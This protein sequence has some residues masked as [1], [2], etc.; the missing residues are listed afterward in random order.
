VNIQSRLKGAAAPVAL[1]IALLAQPAFAQDQGD[2]AT[3]TQAGAEVA[4]NDTADQAIIVTGSRIQRT[5]FSEPNPIVTIDASKIEHYGTA[6]L[7]ELLANNPALLGSV[8]NIDAAGSNLVDAQSTGGNYLDLRNLGSSRTLVLVDGRRHVAGYPGTAS[9]DVNT[10][11]TDLIDRIDVLTG[12]VSAVY[13]ADGVSGVVN[14][15]MK[16][17]FEGLNLRGQRTI[18]QR[19]DAGE[20]FASATAGLNFADGR[21]NIAVAYEFDQTDRFS[22]KQRLNYGLTGP[23]YILTRNPDDGTPGSAD[24]DPN[25]PDHV[26][27]TGL[28][29]AD[30]APGG[31]FLPVDGNLDFIGT[32][33]NGAGQPYDTGMYVPGTPYTIGGDSTPYDTYFG[34][35][36]PYSRR[37]IA[38]LMAHFDASP[39]AQFYVEAKYVNTYAWTESQPT[40]DLYT[41]LAGDNAYANQVL[42]PNMSP[43][44]LLFSRDNLDFGQR[45]YSLKRELWRTVAGVKGDI[46]DNLSYDASFV[47]GQS[48]QTGTNFGDRIADRYY[49]AIDAVDDG[50]GNI[51]C[52]INLPGETDIAGLSFGNPV[53]YNG[54]PETFQKGECV[55][56][57]LFGNGTPSKEA[58]DFILA[59]H[60]DY[61]RIREYVATVSLSGNTGSFLNLPGGPVGFALGGEYRK[62]TSFYDPSD[63]TKQG[64][65]IDNS[66]G[67]TAEGSFDVKELFGEVNLPILQ[68]VPLA[69]TLSLGGAVRY[70]DYSSIGSATTWSVNGEYAPIRDVTFRAT[71]S[72]SVRAPNISEL[73]AP[74]TGAFEF[75][76]DPCGPEL[77]AEGTQYRAANCT[78]ALTALGFTQQ[79]IA[80]FDPADSP[81]SPAN[82]SLLGSQGGNP[83][84][85]AETAKTWTAGAV[86]RP[87]WAPGVSLSLDWYDIKLENAVQ[88]STAQDIVD[89]CYDQP[90]LDND[91][92]ALISRDPTSGFIHNYNVIP[93]NV[94]SFETAG[95]DMNLLYRFDISD[96][97]G[98]VDLRLN[99][100]YLDKI[101]FVPALNAKPENQMDDAGL[102]APRWSANFDA[103]WTKGPVT[104]NYTINWWA[105]TRRVSREAE[106]ANPDYS[107]PKYFWYS[108]LWEHNVFA[109]VDINDMFQVYGGIRNLMDR[110]PD[111]GSAGYPISAVGRTFFFGLRVKAF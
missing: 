12:G 39:A 90:S 19:G 106:A 23:T 76:D 2:S 10:I 57:N 46:T 50:T 30:S 59:D 18:S 73:Y 104:L 42:G 11:P 79:D 109:S 62:E 52:R 43:D 15:I 65:L 38:N 84:L 37:H 45:R 72:K 68:K 96:K 107:D 25:V 92:C 47:F 88:Y 100:N 63:L 5:E 17:D 77:L 74:Q 60:S 40:Y 1:C 55:P 51:T 20:W 35:Y 21:G 85:T 16:K 111:V 95:L 80:D 87:S 54:P 13:G 33:F 36:T 27:L 103:T 94:A 70:S 7:T 14:F 66:P 29:W 83:N 97:L 48:T 32:E 3:D 105:K 9:V 101:Q 75:I 31:A 102:P 56:L 49:A 99:A 8:R 24:D 22:Q 69:Y 6:N 58:L 28:R 98:H 61:A 82:S 53:V 67:D 91:Y 89:L 34:D 108:E 26:L 81:F 4:A 86:I 44:G 93:Q 78:A 110:K 41:Y 71:Y 64:E